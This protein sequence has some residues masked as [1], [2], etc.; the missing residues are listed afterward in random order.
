LKPAQANTLQ[1][2]IL[3]KHHKNK[4]G[5]VTQGEGPE[6]KPQ[7][8]PPKKRKKIHLHMNSGFKTY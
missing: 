1:D 4:A 8:F 6:F 7:Y 5:G 3:K 2:P